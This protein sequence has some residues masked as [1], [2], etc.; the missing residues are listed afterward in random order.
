[1]VGFWRLQVTDQTVE[2]DAVVLAGQ[3]I[4]VLVPAVAGA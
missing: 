3:Q 2:E 4:H 1:M